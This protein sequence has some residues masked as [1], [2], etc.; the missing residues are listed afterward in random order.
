MCEEPHTRTECTPSSK[1]PHD[2]CVEASHAVVQCQHCGTYGI[3]LG[4]QAHVRNRSSA[5][6]APLRIHI[7]TAYRA[8]VCCNSFGRL[9]NA[10]VANCPLWLCIITVETTHLHDKAE[11]CQRHIPK[12]W[13]D[14]L[15]DNRLHS[16]NQSFSTRLAMG[17]ATCKHYLCNNR[18]CKHVVPDTMTHLC[19]V[20]TE[21]RDPNTIRHRWDMMLVKSDSGVLALLLRFHMS[22]HPGVRIQGLYAGPPTHHVPLNTDKCAD[23]RPL[24][25]SSR[26]SRAFIDQAIEKT[27]ADTPHRL[28]TALQSSCMASSRMCPRCRSDLPGRTFALV[29]TA[30]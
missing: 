27:C 29:G 1:T 6:Q 10:R 3:T 13:H 9:G 12:E 17:N 23:I 18:R 14:I 22:V 19:V 8:F 4:L 5:L 15:Q 21:C 26:W 16:V 20:C 24:K 30:A 25:P 2:L 7:S 11:V 28:Y